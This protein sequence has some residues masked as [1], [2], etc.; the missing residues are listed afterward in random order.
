[1]RKVRLQTKILGYFGPLIAAVVVG[2]FWRVDVHMNNRVQAAAREQLATSRRV[3]EELLA[4]RAEGLINAAS[5]V[6]ELGVFYRPVEM[7]DPARLE[8]ACRKINQLVG[9]EV[10][11]LTDRMGVILARTDRRWD[12]GE[13]FRE[14]TAV[15][16][17]LHGERAST[18]WV[19]DGRL[20]AMVSVPVR[21]ETGLAGTL[22]VGY[23]VDGNFALQLSLLSGHEVA[24][25][26]GDGVVAASRKL[27]ASEEQAISALAK[28]LRGGRAVYGKVDLASGL[29]AMVVSPFSEIQGAPAAYAILRPLRG[30]SAEL[31]AIERQMAMIAAVALAA[32]LGIGFVLSR[33]M[34]RPLTDLAAA[35]QQLGG[36]SY[37]FRLP[38]PAGSA[39]IEELTRSFEAMRQSLK[40]RIEELRE[41]TSSLEQ[42][43]GDRTAALER[44]LAENRALLETLRQWN[45]ALERR[46]EERTRDLA[47]A[48]RMLI[49]QDRMAAIG[50]LAAGVA[51]EINNPLG[52]LA[53]FAEGLLDRSQHPALAAEPAFR[54]FPE[55]L[56]LIGQEVDRLKTI[57]QRFLGFARTRSPEKQLIDANSIAKHVLA[58][59]AE[60]AQREG[61]ELAGDLTS[62]EVWIEA[63]PEQLKQAVLNLAI[64]GLDAV[65]RGGSVR[66][67]TAARD[68][69]VEMCVRDN[70][71]G[72]PDE[73]RA[74]VFEPFF[75][76]KPP[77][78]GTGL[79]LAL[80]H[81]LVR[82]NGGEIELKASTVGV[83]SEFV[84][85]LPSAGHT[86]L[87]A[88]A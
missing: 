82:E 13:T 9:S 77:E 12:V 81:D 27:D 85:R 25:L 28:Q 52:I 83:G 63:D 73:L 61:K 4:T 57:V 42:M 5:L 60:H 3:F 84:I 14:T 46:I 31:Q 39:E 10:V 74:R 24:F 64:N 62:A 58:L 20:Y 65:D 35:A 37:D 18:M 26:V 8:A 22:S 21:L 55:Y 47:E 75:S 33:S 19:Q 38:P 15:A 51:H 43:V 69:V 1:V 87:R 78:K 7:S 40:A 53:G 30:D 44:A 45:D 16:R 70:G 67:A 29:P 76:T 72:I 50:R 2:A 36:G 41:L 6:S 17:A 79:G 32:A 34:T 66:I 88:H 68:G 80:C 86:E 49:R 59:L 71:E 23:R 56:R 54:D 11:I 48:Q